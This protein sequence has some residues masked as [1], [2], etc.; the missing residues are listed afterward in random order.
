M[1]RMDNGMHLNFMLF[2]DCSYKEKNE[3]KIHLF[4]NQIEMI[5]SN[6]PNQS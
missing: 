6:L 3:G 4:G 1:G 5:C 2:E